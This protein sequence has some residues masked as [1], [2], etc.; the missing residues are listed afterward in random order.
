ML[1]N[2]GSRHD[3]RRRLVATAGLA[4]LAYGATPMTVHA[5]DASTEAGPAVQEIVVTAQRREQALSKVPMSVTAL[6][7]DGLI[8]AG[9]RSIGDLDGKVP[10]VQSNSP[11]GGSSTP[12]FTI[13]GIGIA[14]EFDAAQAAPVGVYVDDSYLAFRPAHG[15]QLFDTE[16]VE[17][18]SGPQ[19]TLF[20]RNTTGGA[21]NYLTKVPALGKDN[22]EINVE[23]GSNDYVHAEGAL[24]HTLASDTLGVRLAVNYARSDGDYT[25]VVNGVTTPYGAYEDFAARAAIR[26]KLADRLVVDFKIYGANN[27]GDQAPITDP[28]TGPNGVNPLTGYSRQGEGFWTLNLGQPGYLDLRTY[29]AL[30]RVRYTLSEDVQLFF[31]S[32]Y[33]WA[34]YRNAL[35]VDGS[36]LNEAEDYYRADD[37]AINEEA[38]LQYSHGRVN[39][40]VGAYYGRDV[41]FDHDSID[42]FNFLPT[43]AFDIQHT[44]TQLRTSYAGFAQLDYQLTPKISLTGGTRVSHD[45]VL[46]ENAQAYYTDGNGV[47]E[48]MTVPANPT[49]DPNLFLGTLSGKST[50]PTARVAISYTA[51]GGQLYYASYNR[52]YRAGAFGSFG[53]IDAAGIK[54]VRPETV[55]AFEV[56]TKGRLLDNRVR[57]SLAGFYDAYQNQQLENPQAPFT[58]LVNAPKST[59]YGLDAETQFFISRDL[60]LSANLGLLSAHYDTLTLN[61][62]VLDGNQMPFAPTVN[63]SV[64]ADWTFARFGDKTLTYSVTGNFVTKQWY[65]PFDAK[66][67]N[68]DIQQ[69]GYGKVNMQLL[70]NAGRYTFEAWGKNVLSA[71]YNAYALNLKSLGS[72]YFIPGPPA[73]WGVSLGFKF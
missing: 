44:F 12:N 17:I 48:Y 63:G 4:I 60:K 16:R 3:F 21:V 70:Y 20:G 64:T 14:N 45:E 68:G 28:G 10:N 69:G 67:D 5:D 38:R 22:G 35:D 56:G 39:L 18:L 7:G 33:D 24:D 19:G 15:A 34:R 50:A 46:H 31:L 13:R 40:T 37:H 8:A 27:R 29:G 32:S 57:Y 49:Y 59:I 54:Y 58:F 73:T 71:K 9:V 66:D 62:T 61:N 23:G 42:I 2:V 43:A 65:S 52:G 72:D 25:N 6:T 51:D 11:F 41:L 36:P 26:A 47:P 53:Y 30:M 1:K 55:D